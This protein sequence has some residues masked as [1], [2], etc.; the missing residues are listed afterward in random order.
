[1]EQN[2]SG[3]HERG[4]KSGEVVSALVAHNSRRSLGGA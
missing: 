3:G 1:M 2:N 4:F